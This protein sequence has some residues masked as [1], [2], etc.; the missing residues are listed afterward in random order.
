LADQP[1]GT[2][3]SW[4][5]DG[6]RNFVRHYSN[7]EFH[8]VEKLYEF[9]EFESERLWDEG[10]L[11]IE[12]AEENSIPIALTL[13]VDK[14]NKGAMKAIIENAILSAHES[15]FDDDDYEVPDFGPTADTLISGALAL[16][17][18]QC[19]KGPLEVNKKLIITFSMYN[20]ELQ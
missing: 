11:V 15:N 7:G 4:D 16:E 8:G 5:E 20:G 2:F 12:D 1:H 6:D 3:T 13:Y 18:D 10:E 14:K 9:G 17:E 19:L